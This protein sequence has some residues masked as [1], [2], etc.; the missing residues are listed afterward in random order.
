VLPGSSIL[1]QQYVE[2]AMWFRPIVQGTS[3]ART[4]GGI[5]GLPEDGTAYLQSIGGTLM[6][7]FT[8][9]SLFNLDSVDL[10]EYSTVV[11]NAVAVRFVG[12]HPDSSTVTMDWTTDG[13][14]DGSGPLADFQTFGFRGS[15]TGLSRVEIP[16]YGWSL[17]NLIVSIPEPSVGGLLCLAAVLSGLRFFKRKQTS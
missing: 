5:P 1:V 4:G 7:S 3:F 11:S 15:F 6:F 8:N 16:S 13:I 14:I 2:S 12:Y 17:D 10:A 9:G